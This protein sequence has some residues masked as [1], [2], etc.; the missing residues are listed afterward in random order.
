MFEPIHKATHCLFGYAQSFGSL[1]EMAFWE[2]ISVSGRVTRYSEKAA[3]TAIALELA[4]ERKRVSWS[5]ESP[6]LV[7]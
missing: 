3:P 5:A 4:P 1:P 7:D 6:V 2:L